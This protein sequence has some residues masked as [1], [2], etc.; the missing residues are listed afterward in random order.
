[1]KSHT[2]RMSA[3][4]RDVADTLLTDDDPRTDETL[5][6]R[7]G[8]TLDAI[9]IERGLARRRL[10]AASHEPDRRWNSFRPGGVR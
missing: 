4:Q 2:G 8:I 3:L 6:E 9:R 7:Y 10:E 5:A 1:M